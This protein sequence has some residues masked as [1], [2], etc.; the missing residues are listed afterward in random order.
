MAVL[1][2]ANSIDDL[3]R[4]SIADVLN[5]G[6]RIRPSK[7]PALELQSVVLELANPLAR[8]SRSETRGRLFSAL[9]ETCWYLAGTSDASFITYYLEGYSEF[10]ENDRLWGGYGPRWF[11]FGG[12]NQ[13]EY[14]IRKLRSNPESRQAVI[15]VF[16]R[17]DVAHDHLDVPCT[18]TLQF[19]IRSGQLLLIAHMRSNDAYLGLPHDVFAFTF[20]QE[21]IARSIDVPLGTYVHMVGSFHVYESNFA[22]ATTFLGEGWQAGVAM[23]EMPLAD[24]WPALRVLL[25]AEAALRARSLDPLDLALSG[26]SYWDDLARLLA[27]FALIKT[28]RLEDVPRLQATLSSRAFDIFVSD[29]LARA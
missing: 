15:Q 26:G 14:V 13:V 5:R 23:P 1:F 16:D 3:M 28:Q 8:L 25:G 19:L 9:G 12:V 17:T 18:C 2:S 11:S 7:G 27:I 4:E 22:S 10:V 6:V 20:L 21:L 29:R 24:P